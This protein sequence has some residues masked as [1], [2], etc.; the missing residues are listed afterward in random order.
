MP[1]AELFHVSETRGI[2]QFEPRP[3]EGSIGPPVAVQG[4]IG[5]LT[6][7][8]EETAEHAKIAEKRF[9]PRSPRSLRS[10]LASEED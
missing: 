4:C 3:S 8:E 6:R 7:A 1:R 10:F 9:S 2:E 5:S